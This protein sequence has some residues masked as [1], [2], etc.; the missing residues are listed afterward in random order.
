VAARGEDPDRG[1][2]EHPDRDLGH[3]QGREDPPLRQGNGR[4]PPG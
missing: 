4:L 2:G 1:R 3:G